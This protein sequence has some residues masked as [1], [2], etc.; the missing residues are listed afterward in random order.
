MKAKLPDVSAIVAAGA[1]W[2][3]S[4]MLRNSERRRTCI[5]MVENEPP[6]PNSVFVTACFR[7]AYSKKAIG[8]YEMQN[9]GIW[10]GKVLAGKNYL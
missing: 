7:E 3:D 9:H 10:K 4:T 6:T 8:V 1:P 2:K 5:E